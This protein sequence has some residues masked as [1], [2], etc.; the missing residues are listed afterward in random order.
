MKWSMKE[1]S[2]E[3]ACTSG[4]SQPI[5]IVARGARVNR[6]TDLSCVVCDRRRAGVVRGG[7]GAVGGAL[8][9]GGG[10]LDSRLRASWAPAARDS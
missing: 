1:K 4:G 5:S 10:A 2:N 3:G 6:E 9:G 8:L 7:A